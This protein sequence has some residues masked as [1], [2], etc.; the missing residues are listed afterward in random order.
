MDRYTLLLVPESTQAL[1]PTA[2][3]HIP[4][5]TPPSHRV[6]N[7][8]PN[9][10]APQS[11]DGKSTS[12]SLG[13]LWGLNEFIH[14]KHLQQCLTRSKWLIN[15]S[16]MSLIMIII[17][18]I[19]LCPHSWAQHEL[20]HVTPDPRFLNLEDPCLRDSWSKL[21]GK[22]YGG[23]EVRMNSLWGVRMNSLQVEA[24]QM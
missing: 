11:R 18:R 21:D 14:V 13:D 4:V 20:Q 6:T 10:L 9:F 7:R 16:C 23:G 12:S 8:L 24:V 15:G 5:L 22:R 3:V 19:C 2:W 17:L 1:S